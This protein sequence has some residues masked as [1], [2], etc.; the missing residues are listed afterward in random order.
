MSDLGYIKRYAKHELNDWLFDPYYERERKTNGVTQFTLQRARNQTAW[1]LD[2]ANWG[3][4]CKTSD[5]R[6]RFSK[7]FLKHY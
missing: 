4:L 3:R 7:L 2:F 1:H 6:L 5:T